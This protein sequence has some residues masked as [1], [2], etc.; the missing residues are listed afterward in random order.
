MP[1]II[2]TRFNYNQRAPEPETID[3][4]WSSLIDNM[5]ERKILKTQ[6]VAKALFAIDRRDF[7]RSSHKMS[8]TPLP[9]I[10]GK[11]TIS[12]PVIHVRT[13]ELLKDRLRPGMRVLDIGC[14]TG[15]LAACFA[16][17]VSDGG[18][19]K[20]GS[21]VAI[22]IEP[23]LA[24][25]TR[26]N[27]RKKKYLYL[28]D[29]IFVAVSN[30]VTGYEERARYDAIHIGA[31]TQEEDVLKICNQ[32]DENGLCVAPVYDPSVDKIYEGTRIKKPQRICIY[33][34]KGDYVRKIEKEQVRYVK[35]DTTT[36]PK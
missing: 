16:Y 12:S 1:G 13:L 32:L 17:L 4:E 33:R 20:K 6:E 35:L 5:I 15:F 14:G 18:R 19:N 34:R 21:V 26:I 36:Q 7:L 10:E 27:L 25:E 31:A 9:L 2:S 8:T 24:N 30:G 11:A 3:R 22:E 28:K 23:S 29:R